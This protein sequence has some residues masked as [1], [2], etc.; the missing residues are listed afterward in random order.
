VLPLLLPVRPLLLLCLLWQQQLGGAG[1]HRLRRG[2]VALQS[3]KG[4]ETLGV[5]WP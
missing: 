1:S 3:S 2:R 4:C 5:R